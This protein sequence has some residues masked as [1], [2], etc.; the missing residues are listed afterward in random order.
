MGAGEER[1]APEPEAVCA[2]APLL[3]TYAPESGLVLDPFMGSGSTLRAAK[4][5]GLRAVGMEIEEDYCRRAAQRMAQEV[6]FAPPLP[7]EATRT[8]ADE[9]SHE[10]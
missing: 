2:L 5:Q 4:N 6:L 1:L 3:A 7:R 9:N 10:A 8:S